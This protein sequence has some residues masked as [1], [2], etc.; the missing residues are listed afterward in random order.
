MANKHGPAPWRVIIG[1]ARGSAHEV[2]HIPNQDDADSRAAGQAGVVA[3]VADG[4]GAGRHF[5]SST[6]SMLAVR[7]ALGV[8]EELAV[9]VSERWNAD[10]AGALRDKLPLAIVTRWRE[11]VARHHGGHPYSPA[12]QA[13]LDESGDGPEI[14]YGS[15]LLVALIAGGWLVCAQIGD[16]DMLAIRPDGAAWSPVS[17]DERLDG[18]H[19]TSLCQRGA[20]SSFRTAAYD[21]RAEPLLAL[22]L[23]TDGYGNA[24]VADPWQPAV[25]RDLA[26]LAAHHDHRWFE[27]QVPD[28]ADRCASAEGSGDDTTIALLLAP[29]SVRIAAAARPVVP[30]KDADVPA[31]KIVTAGPPMARRSTG[32]ASPPSAPRTAPPGTPAAFPGD[33]ARSRARRFSRRR[34]IIAG[35][36]LLVA[37]AA[38]TAALL[39]AQ[40]SGSGPSQRPADTSVGQ[41]GVHGLSAACPTGIAQFTAIGQ[42]PP[43]A[44]A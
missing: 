12:E 31:V 26:E 14:P 40:S 37:A 38:V 9:E 24:Q 43:G 11:L 16:G 15:T 42:R 7:A 41:A 17:G 36:A 21:L 8:V 44:V 39:A 22:L 23:G 2:R 29:D 20:V 30:A 10:T 4:H 28:W 1:T 33:Q 18:Y 32:T 35:I 19:T 34:A 3:A 5:R 6:G 13:A 25:A 27:R